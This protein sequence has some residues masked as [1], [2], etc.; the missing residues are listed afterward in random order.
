[1]TTTT[2]T[3]SDT[4]GRG[5]SP[6]RTLR[7]GPYSRRVDLR[8]VVVCSVLVVLTLALMIFAL[9]LGSLQLSPTD[10]IDAI[11]DRGSAMRRRVV[12]EW[13]APRVVA[14]AVFGAALAVSGAIFQTLTRNPLGSPDVI[15]FTTGSM[16][17]VLATM[18]L[19]LSGV[20]VTAAGALIGGVVAAAAVYLLSYRHGIQRFRL[21][22]VGIGVGALLQSLNSWFSVAVDVEEALTAAV[23]GAGSLNGLRWP[24]LWPVLVVL[25]VATVSLPFAQRWLR[26]VELGDDT[27]VALGLPVERAKVWLIVIG[28]VCTAVVTA[29]AGPIA[30]VALA[31]PQIARRLVGPDH[32][33]GVASAAVV[34][35]VLLTGADLIAQHALPWTE[36][37]VG[38]VTICIGG[39]YLVWLVARE[40]TRTE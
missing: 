33:S 38:A 23:W 6:S 32:A 34:G 40:T 17:G 8:T 5:S 1:M 27:A 4:A 36:L 12:L 30:F 28:L 13:R 16:S 20:W 3:R 21:I 29:V 11:L 9:T 22:V 14:A 37:P 15:G 35:A 10:V 25:A 26:Q 19:G 2:T 7:L 18:L 24:Q 31:A 39:A